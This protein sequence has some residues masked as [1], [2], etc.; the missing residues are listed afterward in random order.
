M[1]I[2]KAFAGPKWLRLETDEGAFVTQTK[3]TWLDA[4]AV[5]LFTEPG[6]DTMHSVMVPIRL[7]LPSGGTFKLDG[8]VVDSVL[9]VIAR[10]HY[11]AKNSGEFK[12]GAMEVPGEEE[13][14]RILGEGMPGWLFPVM[15]AREQS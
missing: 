7:P 12:P 3:R 13:A 8:G 5:V 15:M 2:L 11:D 1:K 14:K 9:C 6:R 10:R 4:G